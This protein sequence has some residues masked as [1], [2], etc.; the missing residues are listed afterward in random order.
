MRTVPFQLL[1]PVNVRLFFRGV[2]GHKHFRCK[3]IAFHTTDD[4]QRFSDCELSMHAS[5]RNPHALLAAG[6]AELLEF[7]AIEELSENARDLALDDSRPVVFDNDLYVRDSSLPAYLHARCHIRR[8]RLGRS[9]G[10]KGRAFRS[11]WRWPRE[12]G[13]GS[14]FD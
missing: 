13:V 14:G 4:M 10:L 9:C 3:L 8:F 5:R 7:R 1:L 6:L 12:A 2:D 11:L